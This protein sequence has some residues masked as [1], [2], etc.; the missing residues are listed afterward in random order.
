MD[1]LGDHRAACPNSGVLRPRGVPLERAAARICR[2]AGA[3]VTTNVRLA[4]M[5]I[6]VPVNDDRNIEVVANGLPLWHGAQVAVDATLVC[7]VGRDGLPRPRGAAVPGLALQQAARE[8][9][10]GT[11]R[12]LLEARRCRLVVFGLEVGGR[13]SQEALNF[14]RQ[15]ARAKARSQPDWLR[16]SAMQAYSHR[17]SGLA[18]VAAHRA[19][20]ASFLE[21]PS[22]GH[23]Y[24]D[25]EEPAVHDVLADARWTFPVHDSRLPAA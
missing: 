19:F 1:P 11:Y 10:E 13:W 9:R 7:P 21:P 22:G 18:A 6:D 20:A 5:N 23:E 17:W 15:L 16:G 4:H 25:G 12:E 2:E 8:K 14:I 24:M 3:R